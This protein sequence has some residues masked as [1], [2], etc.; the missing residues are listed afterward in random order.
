MRILEDVFRSGLAKKYGTDANF[1]IIVNV[2]R[3]DL[4]IQRYREI[5]E[6]G[7][8]ENPFTQIAISDAIKIEPDFEVGE[9]VTE[10]VKLTD[11]ARREILALRQNL[12]SK[13]MEYE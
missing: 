13:I 7:E 4:E 11:F 5:V 8:V 6:D 3:G 10:T 12:I 2:D 9:E 1:D